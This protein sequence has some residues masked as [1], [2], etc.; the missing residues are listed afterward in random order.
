MLMNKFKNIEWYGDKSVSPVT[1]SSNTI[2]GAAET[3]IDEG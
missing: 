1:Y 2:L 3:R